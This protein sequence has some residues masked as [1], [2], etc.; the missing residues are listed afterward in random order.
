MGLAISRSIVNGHRGRMWLVANVD[1]GTTFR[2]TIPL[3]DA[4][5]TSASAS[6]SPETAGIGAGV[7]V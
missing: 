2:F 4:A 1:A 7:D 5:A 6:P 3:L